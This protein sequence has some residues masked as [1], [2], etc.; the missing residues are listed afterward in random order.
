MH[1]TI[2]GI[3]REWPAATPWMRCLRN[4]KTNPSEKTLPRMAGCVHW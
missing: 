1:N 2:Q 3:N 4:S